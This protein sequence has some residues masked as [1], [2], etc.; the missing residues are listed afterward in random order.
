MNLL[1]DAAVFRGVPRNVTVTVDAPICTPVIFDD[2]FRFSVPDQK[3]RMVNDSVLRFASEGPGRL[4]RIRKKVCCTNCSNDRFFENDPFHDLRVSNLKVR[5][6]GL[7]FDFKK[8][9]FET[10]ISRRHDREV[11]GILGFERQSTS[12]NHQIYRRFDIAGAASLVLG[13]AAHEVHF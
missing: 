3:N 8:I 1:T 5:H 6:P 12:I 2:P 4:W 10:G 9:S 7:I 13:V 11:I